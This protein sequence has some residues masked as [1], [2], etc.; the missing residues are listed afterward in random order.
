M[1]PEVRSTRILLV[2]DHQANL[3]ALEAILEPLGVPLVRALSAVATS[4]KVTV[5]SDGME[6]RTSPT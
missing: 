4:G 6:G 2:D 1:A 3:L 5:M